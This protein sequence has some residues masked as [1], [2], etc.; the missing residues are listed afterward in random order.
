MDKA[1]NKTELWSPARLCL[2]GAY[3]ATNAEVPPVGDPRQL[4]NFLCYHM[5]ERAN[6]GSQPICHV[7]SA[8]AVASNEETDRGLVTHEF[9]DSL[10]IDTMI[11]ALENKA[12]TLLRKLTLFVLVKL[13]GHLFTTDEAFKIGNK[14]SRFVAAWSSAVGEFLREAGPTSPTHIKQV[15][16][17]VFLAMAHLPFLR[18]HLPKE[19]WALI[20]HF[21]HIVL[22]NPPSLQR[23]LKDPGILRFLTKGTSSRPRLNWLGML[24]I[25]YGRLSPEVRKQLEEETR[26]VAEGEYFYHLTSYFNLFDAYLS[27]LTTRIGELDELD[28]AA[29]D[30]QAEREK[31]TRAKDRLILIRNTTKRKSLFLGL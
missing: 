3:S 25:M 17:K 5:K 24:W 10:L 8:F 20:Q 6:F 22:T 31:I 1:D 4:L 23:C 27:N 11:E 7:F 29:S 21:P 2:R 18:E 26:Q 12:F 9:T 28:Q 15:A 16:L 19:R 13:D 14:A 30:L